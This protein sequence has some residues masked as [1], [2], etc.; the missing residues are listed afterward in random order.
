MTHVLTCSLRLAVFGCAFFLST[1]LFAMADASDK[2]IAS[3]DPEVEGMKLHY[4]TAGR[5]T[6]LILLHGHAE[7]SLMWK[8]II[9]V[10]AERFMVIAPGI[11]D[12]AIPRMVST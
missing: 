2:T 9:P 12:S 11:G 5:G 7:T 6:P 10:L 3:H 1:M 8:P 4:L